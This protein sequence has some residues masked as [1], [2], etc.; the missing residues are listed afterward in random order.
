M[1]FA[2]SQARR[3]YFNGRKSATQCHVVSLKLWSSF[4]FYSLWSFVINDIIISTMWCV[5]VHSVAPSKHLSS[6][7]TTSC[8]NSSRRQRCYFSIKCV[9]KLI[10]IKIKMQ[11]ATILRAWEGGPGEGSSTCVHPHKTKTYTYAILNYFWRRKNF[12]KHPFQL[13]L[14]I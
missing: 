9:I 8:P 14:F 2:W 12:L 13:S 3:I 4:I 1:S 5:V 10:I 6:H 7:I 11:T